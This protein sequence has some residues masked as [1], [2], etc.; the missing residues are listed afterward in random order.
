MKPTLNLKCSG[1]YGMYLVH[2]QYE[3]DR[4]KKTF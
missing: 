3:A 1:S 4:E 2:W